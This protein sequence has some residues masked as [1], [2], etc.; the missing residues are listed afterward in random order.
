MLWSLSLK[1]YKSTLCCAY[2]AEAI[3][4]ANRFI[5]LV[6][7][8]GHTVHWTGLGGG[9]GTVMYF[10][11]RNKIA[12]E[13]LAFNSHGGKRERER[14]RGRGRDRERERARERERERTRKLENFT[15]QGT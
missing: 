8:I 4:C 7:E 2:H 14:E 5:M 1:R 12:I 15:H 13:D 9:G 6:K 3:I 10:V 11:G